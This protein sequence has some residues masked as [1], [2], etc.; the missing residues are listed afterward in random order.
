MRATSRLSADA[1]LHFHRTRSCAGASRASGSRESRRYSVLEAVKPVLWA[2]LIFC[3]AA[4]TSSA[5]EVK[6]ELAPAIQE[7]S[8]NSYRWDTEGRRSGGNDDLVSGRKDA[9]GLTEWHAH[10]GQKIWTCYV[11]RG[12]GAFQDFAGWLS[13]REAVKVAKGT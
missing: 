12:R 6:A 4:P 1:Q 3:G 9:T 2:C 10:L 5:A 7:L 8:I 13:L 11:F